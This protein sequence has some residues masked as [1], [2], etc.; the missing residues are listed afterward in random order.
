MTQAEQVVATAEDRDARAGRTLAFLTGAFLFVLVGMV[1]LT[2]AGAPTG[3]TATD[4][5]A[6]LRD[7]ATLYRWGFVFAALVSPLLV[8][9]LLVALRLRT[10]RAGAAELVGSAFLLAYL[11]LV[12]FAY[13]TQ[14][15]LLPRLLA[16][17]A[18]NTALW[19]F[20]SDVSLPYFVDLLGYAIFGVGAVVLGFVFARHAG[21]WRWIGVTLAASGATSIAAFAGYALDVG[22]LESL[23]F[24]SGALTVPLAVLLCV[25]GLRLARGGRAVHT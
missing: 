21:I 5:L 22:W 9:S 19:F 14:F 10:T 2:V 13:A 3:E 6:A 8:P 12:S 7:D 4:Q 11:P 23:T 20:E 1:V 17:E 24:I 18:P 25:A 16:A 15:A